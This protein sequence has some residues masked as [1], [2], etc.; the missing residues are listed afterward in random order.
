MDR[1]WKNLTTKSSKVLVLS[2]LALRVWSTTLGK[3][4][5]RSKN[6]LVSQNLN[7]E[8]LTVKVLQSITKVAK[9]K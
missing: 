2:K 9:V 8:N 1:F 7:V 3:R 4:S 6:R 5:L